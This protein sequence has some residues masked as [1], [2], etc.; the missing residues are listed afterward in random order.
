MCTCRYLYLYTAK[1]HNSF[2]HFFSCICP[3]S[4][5]RQ[6]ITLLSLGTFSWHRDNGIVWSNT[7]LYFVRFVILYLESELALRVVSHFAT[8]ILVIIHKQCVHINSASEL[9]LCK[10]I[11]ELYKVPFSSLQELC[12]TMA[13][14]SLLCGGSAMKCRS[15]GRSNFHFMPDHLKPHTVLSMSTSQW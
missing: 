4:V 12:S 10:F 3:D 2:I 11:H 15:F 14:F 6:N 8:F 1:W 9:Q 7:V 5:Y 13:C